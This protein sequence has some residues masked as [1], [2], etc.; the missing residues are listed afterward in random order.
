MAKT[1]W[2]LLHLKISTAAIS[3]SALLAIATS[4]FAQTHPEY[5]VDKDACPFE[6]CIYREWQTKR[7]T[8]LYAEPNVL[9]SVVGNLTEGTAVTAHTG[10]VQTH[11]GK[12]IVTR[13]FEN[14]RT[15]EVLWVYTYVG[16][17]FYKVW[18]KG[19]FFQEKITFGLR[20]PLPHD[21]GYFEIKPKSVWWVQMTTASGLMG[22]TNTAENFSNKDA[23]S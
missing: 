9:S 4:S 23:C 17:G 18:R 8:R 21:W 2:Q 14:Y 6:C 12:A 1:G 13:D 5:Y 19:K 22:W 10:Q 15:G 11:P 20:E 16:E 7:V 3:V